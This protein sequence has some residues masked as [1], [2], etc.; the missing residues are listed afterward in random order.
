[1]RG[2]DGRI[3]ATHALLAAAALHAG[4]QAV[5]TAVVYPALVATPARDWTAVHA[6]HSRRITRV[7]A[8]VYGSVVAA[9]GWALATLPLSPWLG[10]ALAGSVLTGAATAFSAAPTHARLGRLGPRPEL[11][12]RLV[13]ADAVRL[14]GAVL[15]LGGAAGA[16]G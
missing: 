16:L 2:E 9:W 1:M 15:T 14:A 8:V 11:L 5:V 4:F 13:R 6:A 7:V 12:A 10:V 3:D